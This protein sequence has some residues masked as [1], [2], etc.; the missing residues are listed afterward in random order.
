M[1]E[2]ILSTGHTMIDHGK[3]NYMSYQHPKFK[4]NN[5]FPLSSNHQYN[6]NL[7]PETYIFDTDKIPATTEK[8]FITAFYVTLIFTKPFPDHVKHIFLVG[9][10]LTEFIC[11]TD[12]LLSSSLLT[13]SL[14]FGGKLDDKIINE[15]YASNLQII[16]FY[17]NEYTPSKFTKINLDK[18]PKSVDTI[19]EYYPIS[20][21]GSNNRQIKRIISCI[22]DIHYLTKFPMLEEL[23]A[24]YLSIVPSLNGESQFIEFKFLKNIFKRSCLRDD[25]YYSKYVPTDVNKITD[26]CPIHISTSDFEFSFP[27]LVTLDLFV[28]FE[29]LDA[30]LTTKNLIKSLENCISLVNLSIQFCSD[31]DVEIDFNFPLAKVN[32]NDHVKLKRPTSKKIDNN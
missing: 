18:L 25:L 29:V 6:K 2:I 32:T 16:Q 27:S 14:Q 3:F 30:N 11:K 20:F 4:H 12:S 15:V 21:E 7:I 8:L 17:D 28:N 23:Q 31:K 24:D 13:F 5:Y 19:M 26:D 1:N 10:P 22:Y 9:S